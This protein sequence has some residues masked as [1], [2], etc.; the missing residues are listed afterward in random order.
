VAQQDL[1]PLGEAAA[2]LVPDGSLVGLGSGRAALHFVEALAVRVRDGLRVR[3]VPTSTGT[4]DVAKRGGIP[5]VTLDDVD[6]ID[7]TIDGADEVDRS[8]N[9]IKGLGGALIR[10]KIVATASRRLIIVVGDEKL[11]PVL[12]AR[13]VLPVEVVPFAQSFCEKRL[14][15]IGLPTRL[16]TGPAGPFITDNG[17]RILDCTVSAIANPSELELTL[18]AIPGVV[19]TGLFVGM[20]ES[21]LVQK[22]DGVHVLS[23]SR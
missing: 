7:L 15:A 8:L 13:G 5:L 17:N 12:G 6:S 10:E 14:K 11:V 21:V 19:G 18:R 16:R 22:A 2:K 4:A 23:R 3:G 9:L 20:A 1:R